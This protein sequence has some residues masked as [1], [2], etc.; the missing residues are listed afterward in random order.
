MYL[1]RNTDIKKVV[2]L[3]L[4]AAQAIVLAV[5]EKRLPISVGVLG[6][7]IGLANIITLVSLVFFSFYDTILIVLIRCVVASLF[8]SG[9]VLFMFSIFGGILSAVIMWFMLRFTRR[10]FSFVGISIAGSISH[11]IG[12]ILV[13]SFIISDLSVVSYLPVLMVSGIL[14]GCCT[15]ICS[16]FMV[17]VLKKLNLFEFI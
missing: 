1:K 6:I 10:L 4:L 5:V 17:K 13:I 3:S 16:T 7:E 12:Q 14:Y 11:N 15:G 8:M 2:F 9:Q